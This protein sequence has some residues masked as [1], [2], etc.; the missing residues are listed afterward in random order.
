MPRAPRPVGGPVAGPAEA[1]RRRLA[2]AVVAALV[3]S[4][5]PGPAHL[6]PAA[7]QPQDA[8]VACPEHIVQPGDALGAIAQ[9]RQVEGGAA[10][11]LA[12]NADRIDDADSIRVG[13]SL[14]LPCPGGAEPA[15]QQAAAP[16]T[17][18]AA[19]N[20]SPQ[21]PA[22]Q[23]P[24]RRTLAPDETPDETPDAQATAPPP[25]AEGRTTA[26]APLPVPR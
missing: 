11:L 18:D 1:R 19:E 25:A 16:Q 3:L 20:S 15:P 10:A 22:P 14:R 13:Q 5:G 24:T 8:D 17:P 12:L 4:A 2:P 26:R 21:T 7:A 6:G 9:R 23:N